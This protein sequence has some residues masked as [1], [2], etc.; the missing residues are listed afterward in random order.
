MGVAVAGALAAAIIILA[1]AISAIG[2]TAG[3]IV[4]T[5]ASVGSIVCMLPRR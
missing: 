2:A 4:A 1:N 3:A 5:Q